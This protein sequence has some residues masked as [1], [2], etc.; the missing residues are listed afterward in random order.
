MLV[1]FCGQEAQRNF[2][3]QQHLR[4]AEAEKSK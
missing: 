1:N 3:T 2:L 4:K